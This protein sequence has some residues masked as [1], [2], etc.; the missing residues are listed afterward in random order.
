MTADG[1]AA[2]AR[3]ENTLTVKAFWLAKCSN[4]RGA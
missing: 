2:A 4:R 1:T 3:Y